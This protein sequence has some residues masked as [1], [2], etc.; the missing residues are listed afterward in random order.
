[1]QSVDAS[2]LS[3][4][5]NGNGF[6]AEGF[7]F[8]DGSTHLLEELDL[9][10][11]N[12]LE[13]NK[14]L[15]QQDEQRDVI[16]KHDDQQEEEE[17]EEEEEVHLPSAT[18]DAMETYSNIK[19]NI[20][21]G[22]ATGKSIAEESMPCECKY[23]PD[24]DNPN[25]A[26]GDDNE[27][28]NR[29]MFMECM[30]DDC[31]CDRYCRNRRFQLRQ[32]ARVDVIRTEK[33]GF[34]L[35]ALT[36]LPSNAFIMEYIGEVITNNEFVR[37]TKEYEAAGLEH[38]YFMTLK[39]DEIIDAT[40]KGCLARFI[41]HSCNPNSVTQK[42]VVGKN[43]RIGIFTRR[44][45][46]AG[47]ELTFDYKFERYG[48]VAQKCYC[49]EY[50]C[51]GYIGGSYEPDESAQVSSASSSED[52]LNSD[53][54]DDDDDDD[55]SMNDQ[56]EEDEEEEEIMAP[57]TLTQKKMLRRIHRNRAVSPLHD[58]D[59]VQSFVKRMLDSVGK[60]HLVIKLLLRLELTSSS[61]QGKDVL[62]K[63]IQLHGLKMLK[64][65]LGEWKKDINIL[66]KV[67]FVLSQLPLANKN[68]L[69][70]CKMFEVVER[71]TTHQDETISNTSQQLLMDWSQ[72]KSVYRI[73]KR[74]PSES[75]KQQN[76]IHDTTNSGLL[77]DKDAHITQ[78]TAV[79]RRFESSREFFDPDDDLFEYF[80]MFTDFDEI[81][82]KTE[83]PPRSSIPTAPRA[84]IDACIK[85]GFYGY[86]KPARTSTA[87][88]SLL[89]NNEEGDIQL[90]ASSS[91][92]SSSSA[93]PTFT[94]YYPTPLSN[95]NSP[96]SSVPPSS[97]SS[98]LGSV[99]PKLP[100]NWKSANTED[101]A[102]YYY[103]K[104]TGKTQ[105]SIPE[106]R[107]STIEGVNQS[108]L[109]DLVE[110][111]IQD[112]E[113]KKLK[114]M[115]HHKSPLY[116]SPLN[117]A[118]ET[119]VSLDE[120]ELK[121]EVGKIVTKYLSTKKTELWNGDKY[122]FKE[123]AR[124]MT[125]HIVDRETQS[126]RK[127][128]A[129]TTSV[130]SK[131][132]KFIDSHGQDILSKITRKKKQSVAKTSDEKTIWSSAESTS[133][134]D[135]P[136]QPL[137]Q[138]PQP[139]QPPVRSFDSEQSTTSNTASPM[140]VDY[141]KNEKISQYRRYNDTSFE[142]ARYKRPSYA[143]YYRYPPLYYRDNNRYYSPTRRPP[144]YRPRRPSISDD[145][146]D[147]RRWD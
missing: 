11:F 146:M 131:I 127:I 123:L 61:E 41:N 9:K 65:W 29:M 10:R 5:F 75:D 4:G 92:T 141:F 94:N 2:T 118:T 73:P 76:L 129:M 90:K 117:T 134:S 67:L 15:F 20:Y 51:K 48:A 84:M 126:S 99:Q 86:G 21:C 12:E 130:R 19:S 59:E 25:A 54:E 35:R 57:V 14:R 17:E 108:D 46:K 63:F 111:A 72:L 87:T 34:G 1:M 112:T 135:L 93:S 139:Q 120:A 88:S 79:S 44:P 31:P 142:Y 55:N 133:S 32:Y 36:D 16:L 3:L 45:V 102:M 38:Y 22:T 83:F 26:C 122:L 69:E 52:D 56:E 24:L 27:C 89:Y 33:K 18:A 121:K 96:P 8:Q 138:P 100:T 30:V 104:I 98:S 40:K 42:W 95:T 50:N 125:H 85:N 6:Q 43:M 80:S 78:E 60:S 82:W 37:R 97:S 71:L 64:F 70:D 115:N 116:N 53:N 128:Q 101:G 107:V 77:L 28:I 119:T 113:K 143:P 110:K 7:D 23:R 13:L 91:S 144:Y 103:N 105:W 140:E 124:K 147:R 114:S 136:Q 66:K 49:G 109:E 68:G 137:Q 39:T 106:E 58:P 145:D 62:R 74:A 81:Q 47:T 132:E